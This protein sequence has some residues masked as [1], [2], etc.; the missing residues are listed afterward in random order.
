MYKPPTFVYSL[1]FHFSHWSIIKLF[2]A[3]L[4]VCFIT[5]RRPILCTPVCLRSW[6][7]SFFLPFH[8]HSP[9][10]NQR[11]I[12]LGKSKHISGTVFHE[13]YTH[14]VDKLRIARK[15]CTPSILNNLN[16]SYRRLHS[17]LLS[18][19]TFTSQHFPGSIFVDSLKYSLPISKI[20]LLLLFRISRPREEHKVHT[21]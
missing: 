16:I 2:P 19:T 1:H 5:C 11:Q 9:K 3:L 6:R 4:S 17:P 10:S 7:F 21:P 13:H 12:S 20:F 15:R 8:S 14:K 18:F